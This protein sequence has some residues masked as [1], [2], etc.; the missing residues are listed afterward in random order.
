MGHCA[1]CE[2]RDSE[3]SFLRSQVTEMQDRLLALTN[4]AG[5][6][7]YKGMPLA[8][9]G[10]ELG[11]AGNPDGTPVDPGDVMMFIGGRQVKRSEYEQTMAKVEEQMSGR[12][13]G[14]GQ[15]VPV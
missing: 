14:D 12:S 11:P 6:Q 7:I 4:P 13:P 2:A 8:A 10:P 1:G 3:I 9:Q 15:G 5:Y